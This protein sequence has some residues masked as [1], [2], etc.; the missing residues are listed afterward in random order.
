PIPTALNLPTPIIH[1]F[2]LPYQTTL[3]QY[4]HTHLHQQLSN[5]FQLH[6]FKHH[7][8]LLTNYLTFYK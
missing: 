5:Q 8:P 3:K 1:T 7:L 4:S 6:H 2:L